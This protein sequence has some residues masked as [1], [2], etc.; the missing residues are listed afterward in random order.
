MHHIR[1]LLLALALGSP[2]V[3]AAADEEIRFKKGEASAT[4]RGEV[5]AFIKSYTFRARKGQ[6]ISVNLEPAGG[7][8][9]MLTLSM[10]AFCGEQYGTPLFFD[11][12]VRWN[13]TLPCNGDYGID[14]TPSEE[15]RAAKR[16]QRY[17]LTLTIR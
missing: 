10:S 12:V 16:V 1:S 7:D 11:N 3:V 8:R 4:V 15:A 2:V 17:T 9:G 6:T 5:S 14:V 13:G